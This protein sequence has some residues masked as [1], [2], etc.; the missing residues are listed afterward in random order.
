M[1]ALTQIYVDPSLN[2]NSGTGTDVDPYGDLQ[3]ALNTAT[4][5]GTNGNRINIKAGAAEVLSA[6]LN[7]TNFTTPT[8]AVAPIVFAGWD[9]VGVIDGGG[10]A[11]ISTS[12]H[13]H[14]RD[15]EIKNGGSSTLVATAGAGCSIIRCKIDNT[16]GIG[17]DLGGAN[18]LVSE[19]EITD[20]GQG[21]VCGAA[22]GTIVNNYFKFGTNRNFTTALQN[23]ATGIQICE[24]NTFS[25]GTSGSALL[26]NGTGMRFVSN[27]ILANGSNGAGIVL[28]SITRSVNMAIENNVI[29]GFS[30]PGGRGIS[31]INTTS[32]P[33]R[34]AHNACFNN[35]TNYHQIGD[36]IAIEDI[37]NEVL[38]A[39]PFAKTGADTFANRFAYFAPVDTGNIRGGA[40][41]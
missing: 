31:F 10:G 23:T 36:A 38:T 22:Q 41:Q 15:L 28:N 8:S 30:D 18:C 16:S 35:E 12:A 26:I 39:S 34:Y 25:V 27:S 24:R 1:G 3:Y 29:E 13:M 33:L 7:F 32:V 19:C 4:R 17:I 9:G 21:V 37:D 11:M 40:I 5:D 14:F 2:S 20:C 6:I